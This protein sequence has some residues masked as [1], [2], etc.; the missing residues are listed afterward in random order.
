[1]GWSASIHGFYNRLGRGL[2][3]P[4]RATRQALYGDAPSLFEQYR[5]REWNVV[6]TAI[7][8]V[9]RKLT[10]ISELGNELLRPRLQ[11]ILA[12]TN[13]AAL[14]ET[15]HAAHHRVD[16][17]AELADLIAVELAEFKLDSPRYYEFFKR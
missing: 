12:G 5:E 7:E 3:W 6:L 9:L 2:T 10:W 14:L 4:I 11:S 8:K 16:L 13:R 17:H 1:E 15:I